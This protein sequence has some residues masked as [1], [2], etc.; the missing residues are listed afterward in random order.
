M[1][2]GTPQPSNVLWMVSFPISLAPGTPGQGD[3]GEFN[4][5]TCLYLS[6]DVTTN[7]HTLGGL[8]QRKRMISQF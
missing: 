1:V 5:R 3:W 2:L 4:G 6:G 7:Y 8:K